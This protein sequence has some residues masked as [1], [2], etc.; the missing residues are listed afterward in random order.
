MATPKVFISSTCF[1]LGEIR[2]QLQ[3]FVR[4]FG[5]EPILSEH[6]DIFYHPDLHTHESCVY[7]V[8][9]CQLFILII[10]GRFGGQYVSDKTKSITNAE[11]EAAKRQKIPIF[12][13]VKS[14]V[15]S[16]HHVYK[17]NKDNDFVA[18]IEYPSIEKNEHALE[19]FRFI[20][21]VRRAP[22]NNSLEAFEKFIEIEAHLRKQWAGMFFDF[23]K[24]REVKHQIDATNH[25][26]SGIAASSSKLEE[27]V[28]SLYRELSEDSANERIDSIEVKAKTEEFYNSAFA[29][30]LNLHCDIDLELPSINAKTMASINPLTHT[31]YEYLIATGMFKEYP[32]FDD[33]DIAIAHF[34]ENHGYSFKLSDQPDIADLYEHGVKRSS[35]KERES[36]IMEIIPK[37]KKQLSILRQGR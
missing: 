25:L 26:I 37:Y 35:E 31:W 13:Y 5:F 21:E 32:P 16:S 20:D 29:L 22:N 7:E 6:G 12:S 10:G 30:D 9:N 23:L 36:I 27:L 19:I 3:K 4:S 18:K 33:D 8:S 28:K 11:Y 24:T 14:G 2:D 34:T 15:L 17:Q 1:D